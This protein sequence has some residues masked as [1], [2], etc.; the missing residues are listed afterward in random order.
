M[1]FGKRLSLS[2]RVFSKPEKITMSD[3][4]K[5][6]GMKELNTESM[7]RITRII[8]VFM[9]KAA[10]LS[11]E[12]AQRIIDNYIDV[13]NFCGQDFADSLALSELG[14]SN[15]SIFARVLGSRNIS[16][17]RLR[18]ELSKLI[19]K[20]KDNNVEALSYVA[21][22][23]GRNTCIGTLA[24]QILNILNGTE[25]KMLSS[26]KWKP[27]TPVT[28]ELLDNLADV[29]QLKLFAYALYLGVNTQGRDADKVSE[30]Y[31]NL[32][33]A[34][35]T[36]NTDI[37]KGYDIEV[38]SDSKKVFQIATVYSMLS[39]I[40]ESFSKW[41][42]SADEKPGTPKRILKLSN[43]AGSYEDRDSGNFTRVTR[44]IGEGLRG[45]VSLSNSPIG[46]ATDDKAK[47]KLYNSTLK[48]ITKLASGWNINTRQIALRMETAAKVLQV[49]NPPENDGTLLQLLDQA[50]L[51]KRLD[52]AV[53]I[54]SDQEMSER[55]DS[56]YKKD[57]GD[58]I[59]KELGM[60]G[61]RKDKDKARRE[62][63]LVSID[64][65]NGL[66]KKY[67][68]YG[69]DK[70]DVFKEFGYEFSTIDGNIGSLQNQLDTEQ[71]FSDNEK[72]IIRQ[73][74]M[75]MPDLGVPGQAGTAIFRADFD[76]RKFIAE[77]KKIYQGVKNEIQKRQVSLEDESRY[78]LIIEHTKRDE[79]D[80]G[81]ASAFN[82]ASRTTDSGNRQII[83]DTGFAANIMAISSATGDTGFAIEVSLMKNQH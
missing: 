35:G 68:H 9:S 64:F 77:Y 81:H 25:S 34:V 12:Q 59:I 3:L 74:A 60:Y 51:P 70:E 73:I 36:E 56:A 22:K 55:F 11:A 46:R 45:I 40:D 23:F 80:G 43:L 66:V 32:Q 78:S 10:Y 79:D 17:K 39:E 63:A 48:L 58:K 21:K 67:E 72:N 30:N 69:I 13:R 16:D 18:R 38:I 75:R 24:N 50:L 41:L 29:E 20:S 6:S 1:G 57:N 26:L 33:R 44:R 42:L 65:I 52:V 4:L 47:E 7:E 8:R 19:K 27:G 37:I 5:V 28:K 62:G 83:M 49:M 15:Y 71:Q 61:V 2:R 54:A 53:D 82:M 14:A 76:A 31:N